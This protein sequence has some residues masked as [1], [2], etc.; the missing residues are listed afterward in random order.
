MRDLVAFPLPF[1]NLFLFLGLV[2]F[3]FVLLISDDM[4][5]DD[6]EAAVTLLGVAAL[7]PQA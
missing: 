1:L 7:V 4:P 2:D 6:K 5:S 3:W